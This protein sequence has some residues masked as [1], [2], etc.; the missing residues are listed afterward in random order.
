MQAI[1]FRNWTNEEFTW[2]YNGIPHVFPAGMEIYMESDKAEH[3]AKHLTDR[4]MHKLGI[5]TDMETKRKELTAKCFPSDVVVTP[6]IALD[7]NEKA[8]VKKGKKVEVEF[9]DLKK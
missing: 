5:P 4:E 1:K 3:F 6:E 9:P 8:K 7:I 2:K